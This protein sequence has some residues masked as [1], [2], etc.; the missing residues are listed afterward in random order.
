METIMCMQIW[1]LRNIYRKIF[2]D[3]VP[4][5]SASHPVLRRLG[6]GTDLF[7]PILLGEERSPSRDG[8]GVLDT[9]KS[10]AKYAEQ[11]PLGLAQN[12]LFLVTCYFA[13]PQPEATSD[14]WT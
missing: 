2:N 10:L 5:D 12:V 4:Q 11:Y 13:S 7:R 1:L 3:L 8:T 6:R 9:Y 14:S